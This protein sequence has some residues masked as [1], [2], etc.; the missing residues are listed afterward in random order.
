MQ[1]VFKPDKPMIL[2]IEDDAISRRALGAL[3]RNSGYDTLAVGSAEEAKWLIINGASPSVALV[4]VDLP[5]TNGLELVSWMREEAPQTVPMLVT[6]SDT[7]VVDEFR[8]FHPCRYF[9][10]PLD[11]PHL[12]QSLESPAHLN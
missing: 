1:D 7:D 9:K 4:D 10:K 5:G 6:A 2:V 3:L 8:S 12:L 11:L